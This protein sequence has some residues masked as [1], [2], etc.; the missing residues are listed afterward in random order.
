MHIWTLMI[1]QHDVDNF[2]CI[3]SGYLRGSSN[4][5]TEHA[6]YVHQNQHGLLI[7]YAK[8]LLQLQQNLNMGT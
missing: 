3:S 2:I 1:M 5:R 4:T 7:L 6:A 8:R